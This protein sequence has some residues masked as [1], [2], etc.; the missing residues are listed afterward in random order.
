VDKDGK[1]LFY[2]FVSGSPCCSAVLCA[3]CSPVTLWVG[4]CR[5]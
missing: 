3:S 5:S 4:P 2:D 1:L